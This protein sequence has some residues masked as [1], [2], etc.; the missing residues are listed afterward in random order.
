[1]SNKTIDI[2]SAEEL[3][4]NPK[5]SADTHVTILGAGASI[6][7]FLNGDKNGKKV[8]SMDQL[9]DILGLDWTNLIK[10]AKPPTGNFEYQFSWLK[11]NG[12]CDEELRYI[13]QLIEEYFKN[14]ELPDSPTIYD[15]LVLGLRGKYIIATFNWDPFL[16]LAHKRNRNIVELPDI[17]F[18]HG[19]VN[20]A[21]CIEHD[22][23][24]IE[25]ESCPICEKKLTRGGLVFPVND[26]DY[27][28]DKVVHQD[29]LR[30]QKALNSSVHCTIFGYSGPKTDYM[31]RK[32]IL[33][34]WN[35]SPS[36][37]NNYLEVIDIKSE[38][39][40]SENWKVFYPHGHSLY[41]NNFWDSMLFHYP[42][43]ITEAKYN[44]SVM[45]LPT[46][47]LNPPII[48]NLSELQCW[49]KEIA[50]FEEIENMSPKVQK[51][52]S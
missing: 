6:A 39:E 3:V 49:Y 46:R 11:G 18:L 40:V 1:M 44:A 43:R 10:K 9:P 21:T 4:K 7:A 22:V 23:L 45:G 47:Y 34:S 2:V 50:G 17:R 42:R 48:D 12:N 36:Y 14:F 52:E 29:W 35:K 37:R 19:S 33:E 26:K 28:I 16:L 5:K 30:I 24:G 32:L 8:P 15:Y 51:L 31:A 27:T 41:S 25:A 20:Y 13:E 38:S